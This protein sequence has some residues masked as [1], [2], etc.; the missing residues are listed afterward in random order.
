MLLIY[1]YFV[2]FINQ[3]LCYASIWYSRLDYGIVKFLIRLLQEYKQIFEL[4]YYTY[5]GRL[6]VHLSLSLDWNRSHWFDLEI[7]FQAIIMRL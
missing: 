7:N 2:Y 4:H 3:N 5:S 6:Y 1:I